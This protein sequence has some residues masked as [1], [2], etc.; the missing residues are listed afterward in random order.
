MHISEDLKFRSAPVVQAKSSPA[1]LPSLAPLPT[2]TPTPPDVENRADLRRYAANSIEALENA[3]KHRRGHAK[4]TPSDVVQTFFPLATL[5]P[6]SFSSRS[7]F[8]LS[9]SLSLSLSLS[10]FFRS[11]ESLGEKGERKTRPRFFSRQASIVGNFTTL[12]DSH[13]IDAHSRDRR[14]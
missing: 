14:L 6:L 5:A 2:P 10:V 3:R 9:C 8:P 7:A 4:Q 1:W 13:R 11:F 12:V